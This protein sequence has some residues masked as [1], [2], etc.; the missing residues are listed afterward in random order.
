[1]RLFFNSYRDR[2][3]EAF[4]YSVCGNMNTFRATA[5]GEVARQWRLSP[6][7]SRAKERFL[8]RVGR[9]QPVH[10]AE[11]NRGRPGVRNGWIDGATTKEAQPQYD[12]P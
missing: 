5:S 9:L 2:P 6:D 8:S 11:A 4:F 3:D 1:M 10:G 7:R 12:R